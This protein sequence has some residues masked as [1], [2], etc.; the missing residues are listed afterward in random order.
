MSDRPPS[1]KENAV[2]VL[3]NHYLEAL[4]ELSV[5]GI[6]IGVALHEEDNHDALVKVVGPATDALNLAAAIVKMLRPED[7]RN[8]LLVMQNSDYFATARGV[9]EMTPKAKVN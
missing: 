2:Y 8:L 9:I 6:V 3:T 4:A 7:F 5:Y 1:V